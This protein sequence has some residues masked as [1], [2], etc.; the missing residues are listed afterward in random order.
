MNRVINFRSDTFTQP[1]MRMRRAMQN[2][3]VGD[4]VYGEDPTVNKLETLAAKIV[5]KEDSIFVPSGT[6]G[7]LIAMMV[8]CNPGQEVI[9]ESE[10][11]I[12][13]YETG[14]IASIAGLLPRIIKGKNGLFTVKDIEKVLRK[15]DIHYPNSALICIES[16]HNRG[17]GTVMPLKDMEG[18][19][20]LAKG[21]GIK[22]HLD[23]SRIFNAAHYL[24]INVK[25]I[26]SQVD[27]VMFCLSKGL[28]A[29]VGSM[30]CGTSEFVK[31]GKK[32][33]KML[34][35]GMRQSGVIAATAIIALENMIPRLA[36]DNENALRLAKSIV[37]TPGVRFDINT[38]QTNIINFDV[39]ELG[40]TALE[41]SNKLY[42]DFNI[43]VSIHSEYTLRMV[44]HRHISMQDIDYTINAINEIVKDLKRTVK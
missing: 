4:D 1:T 8:Y 12:Y 33:R 11:H 39:S 10:S 37:N 2:A 32:I 38:V 9:L 5:G 15:D 14:G 44:L 29:P 19:Y 3:V 24:K 43:Q 27:S 13:N 17:G 30:V 40:I 42:N 7:N 18:I 36:K 28:S 25:E 22:V 16:P 20:K 35:G 21:H 26:T 6:M 41:F 23:G 31:K 34:G